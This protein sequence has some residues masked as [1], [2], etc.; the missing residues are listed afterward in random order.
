MNTRVRTNDIL[1]IGG[2]ILVGFGLTL[3][4]D[5]Y[6][7]DADFRDSLVFGG[8]A[9]ASIVALV[10][11]RLYG[12]I[13]STMLF[14]GLSAAKYAVMLGEDSGG[15]VLLGPGVAFLAIYAIGALAFDRTHWW[16]LVPGAILTLLG[17]LLVFGGQAGNEL[18]GQIWPIVLLGIGVLVLEGFFARRRAQTAGHGMAKAG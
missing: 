12:F 5:R 8:V 10:A 11:T 1:W 14:A 3:V 18:A 16:P 15:A 13:L 17:G 4:A 9:V 2:V 7:T 6:T